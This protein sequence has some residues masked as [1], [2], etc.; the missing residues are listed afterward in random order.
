MDAYVEIIVHSLSETVASLKEKIDQAVDV[1]VSKQK[2]SGKTGLLKDNK[3]LAYY[4]VGAGEMLTLSLGWM[5]R[6]AL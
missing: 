1:P 2:I 3:S 6:N 5:R 4:N